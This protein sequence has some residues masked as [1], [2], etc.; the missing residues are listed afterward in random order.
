MRKKHKCG[1]GSHRC[2][3]YVEEMFE[4]VASIICI[5]QKTYTAFIIFQPSFKQTLQ[6]YHLFHQENRTRNQS[7]VNPTK[8]SVGSFSVQLQWTWQNISRVDVSH[9]WRRK[10]IFS[11]IL[12]SLKFPISPH[13]S[14]SKIV[15]LVFLVSAK[16]AGNEGPP[17]SLQ[18]TFV[19]DF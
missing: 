3:Y 9:T 14:A 10:K 2:F 11:K 18:Y 13:I 1:N 12:W 15:D 16:E 5:C 17:S 7:F 8:W 19:N 4:S 6:I